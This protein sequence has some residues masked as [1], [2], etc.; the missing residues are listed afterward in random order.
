MWQPKLTTQRM[1]IP[2]GRNGLSDWQG[3]ESQPEN[4]KRRKIMLTYAY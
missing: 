2:A 4:S 3:D 1:L